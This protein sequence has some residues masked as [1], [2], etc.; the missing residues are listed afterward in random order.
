MKRLFLIVFILI[1]LSCKSQTSVKSVWTPEYEQQVSDGVDASIKP[2]MP[3]EVL[4]K[5]LVT[6]IVM[7]LKAELPKGIKSVSSDSLFRLSVKIGKDYAYMNGA[8]KPGFESGIT[9][10]MTAWKPELEKV[11]RDAVMLKVGSLKDEN[12]RNQLCDCVVRKVR[13]IYPDSVMIP[14]PREV[15]LKVAGEC[16]DEI[17]GKGK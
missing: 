6:Y 17:I 8:E 16:H 11:F 13:V 1:S 4:R 15:I 9:P 2:R 14:L 7:R 5:K 3:D 10:K 12:Y